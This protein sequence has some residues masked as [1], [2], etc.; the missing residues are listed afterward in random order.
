MEFCREK[1]MKMNHTIPSGPSTRMPRGCPGSMMAMIMGHRQAGSV[2]SSF[3]SY[4]MK[5]SC[6][7]SPRFPLQ[8]ILLLP[9]IGELGVADVS[10]VL[11]FPCPTCPDLNLVRP[12][13]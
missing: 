1:K 13:L 12:T 8:M 11:P 4:V 10:P 7:H 5:F 2:F 9:T 6:R 3:Y